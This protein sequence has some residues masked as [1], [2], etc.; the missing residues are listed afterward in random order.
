MMNHEITA[1]AGKHKARRRR[2]RGPGSGLGKT[3]GSGH[4]G[5]LARAGAHVPLATEGGQMPLFR[6]IPKRGFSN[7]VFTKCYSIVNV[8]QLEC[9]AEGARVDAQMLKDAGLIRT[10]GQWVKVLG[11]GELN[12]RLT[13]V[14]DKFSRSARQKI[15]SAGG[16]VE[17]VSAAG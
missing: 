3:S 9:F 14:A 16:A 6:R 8:A 13:V 4:K 11:N 10:T 15:T 5:Q 2:G 1:A 7:A 17:E 12:R